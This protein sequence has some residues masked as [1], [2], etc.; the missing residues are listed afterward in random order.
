[1]FIFILTEA[2]NAK[3]MNKKIQNNGG[4]VDPTP[5]GASKRTYGPF[6]NKNKNRFFKIIYI[7]CIMNI[8]FLSIYINNYMKIYKIKFV[9]I[10]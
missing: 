9:F 5:K 4:I 1:M 3:N 8:L 2:T 6:K 10:K 7:L